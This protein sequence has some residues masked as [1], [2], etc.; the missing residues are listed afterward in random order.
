MTSQTRR[1]A[2]VRMLPIDL[3]VALV[4]LVALAAGFVLREQVTGR[5]QTFAEEGAPFT[6]TYPATWGALDPVEGTIM[7][8]VNPISPSAFKT[9]LQVDRRD[10]DPASPPDLQ[11]LVDRRI[12]ERSALTGYHFMGRSDTTVDGAPAAQIDY[13]YV[14]QP[15][16]TPGR[17]ALPVV[18]MAREYIVLAGGTSYYIRMAAPE[19]SAEAA[20]R[21]FDTIIG[22]VN[23]Q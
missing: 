2:P 19:A 4:V 3:G 14:V 21:Q 9:A 6:L 15:I 8:V 23:L 10:L 7:S 20:F 16:D 13:A 12:E 17:A 18:V 11:T 5:T 22:T 1:I